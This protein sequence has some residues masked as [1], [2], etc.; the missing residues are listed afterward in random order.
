[1]DPINMQDIE[2]EE[3]T[4]YEYLGYTFNNKDNIAMRLEKL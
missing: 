3:T 2:I 4:K 1:M